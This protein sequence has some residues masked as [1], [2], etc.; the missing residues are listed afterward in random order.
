MER[1]EGEQ[2][3]AEPPKENCLPESAYT[4]QPRR[5]HVS[6]AS[7]ELYFLYSSSF[8]CTTTRIS[9]LGNCYYVLNIQHLEQC[10]PHTQY[11]PK[12]FNVYVRHIHV[13]ITHTAFNITYFCILHKNIHCSVLYEMADV[14]L[15]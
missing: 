10:L 7:T 12:Y 3:A 5:P 4:L 6:F 11:I 8:L 15:F 2:R 13:N 1:H 9:G 14:K